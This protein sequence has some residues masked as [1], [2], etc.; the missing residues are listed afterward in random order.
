MSKRPV[1]ILGAAVGLLIA[2][3]LYLWLRLYF[4]GMTSSSMEPTLR[5]GEQLVVDSAAGNVGRG[6]LVMF[7]Y[8]P[9]PSVLYIM[10]V[11]GVGGDLVQLRGAEVIVNGEPLRERR[12]FV[13]YGDEAEVLREV[14]KEGEGDYSVYYAKDGE[15]RPEA[16]Y[17]AREP[18]RVPAGHVFTLG[19]NRDNSFDSRFWGPVPAANVVG[20]PMFVYAVKEDGDL[21][22]TH[23]ALR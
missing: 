13:V 16:E 1:L 21:T 4:V 18:H 3:S 15:A 8:P 11:V 17:A 2:V 14:G 22:L 23:R 10:R 6:D 12:T 5:P 9:E 7:R 20:R 19:D